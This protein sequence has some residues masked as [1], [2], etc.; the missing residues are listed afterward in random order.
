[1]FFLSSQEDVAYLVS[2]KYITVALQIK[3]VT[4]VLLFVFSAANLDCGAHGV[5]EAF[6]VG[7]QASNFNCEILTS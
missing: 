3:S 7:N 2:H 4:V 5:A 6:Q 1:M